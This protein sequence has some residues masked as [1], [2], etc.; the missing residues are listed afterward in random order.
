MAISK[1]NAL[2]LVTAIFIGIIVGLIISTNFDLILNTTASDKDNY[3]NE[4]N[5]TSDAEGDYNESSL[6]TAD[7]ESSGN[8]ISGLL[9]LEK[10][11][12]NVSK[13]V[14]PWV[15]TITSEKYIKY[16]QFD[17]FE[18]FG[19][20]L[21]NFFGGRD[22]N[23]RG[24]RQKE[25]TYVQQGL[26]SGVIVSADGYI[27]TNNHVVQE[28]D[29]IRVITMDKKEYKAELIGRDDKTDVAVVKIKDKNL[30]FAK[31]G[32]SEK[33]QVG[34]IVLAVGNPFSQELQL[35]VTNG[36]ISAKGRSGIG[37]GTFYQ[38]FIQT[39]AAINPGNSG[40]ALVNLKGELIGI[41]SAIISRSGG[42]N[43]IG[44]AIPINMAKHIM[45]MLIENGYVVRGYLGVIPQPLT[46]E[47]AQAL[48]MKDS[49]GALIT[50]V[51]KGTPAY[52][53]GLKEED[54]IVAIDGKRVKDV[55]EFRWR[56]AEYAPGSKV[57]LRVF[58]NGKFL[59]I[60]V[61]LEKHPDDQPKKEVAE[62]ESKKLGV[63]VE[64]L[65]R[66]IERQ[67]GY[68]DEEGVL[69][70]DVKRN[71]Q[72]YHNGIREGDLI[73]AINRKSIRSV[74]DYNRIV[75]KAKAGDILLIRLK[76]RAADSINTWYVS[77]RVPD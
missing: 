44:F 62:K 56:I 2:F 64:N 39:T 41:N 22:R 18:F 5:I 48:G 36:I 11:Y 29:E 47:M 53:A 4:N 40:G 32:D 67:Y 49:H 3:Q 72:A 1:K 15:V 70:T 74:R 50:T 9:E 59:T 13:K 26:G 76:K 69:V 25:K 54:V 77:V 10:A 37:T 38:D 19:G 20:D 17:P 63:T 30:P 24:S 23:N 12:V 66:N 31:L 75:D 35:T 21:F 34:Q 27:L 42:F 46:E 57:M 65:T 68:E 33:I 7:S 61:N 58:R 60:S 28:A 6:S 71:S 8:D 73:T 43:G 51:E 55:T 45:E 52:K 16:K 14:K